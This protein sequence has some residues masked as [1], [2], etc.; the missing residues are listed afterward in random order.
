[1]LSIRASFITAFGIVF[2]SILAIPQAANAEPVTISSGFVSVT[3]NIRDTLSFNFSGD[4]LSANGFNLHAAVPQYMSP[5]LSS[6]SLC[7]PGDL[8]FPNSLIQLSAEP[9]SG[10]SVTFNGT[11]V[12]V[13]WAAQDSFLQ[14]TGS[15]VVIPSGADQITLT[16][17]F[18]MV[19]TIQVHPLDD[20]GS[21][22]FSTEINGSGIATLT[23]RRPGGNPAGFAI[24][25]ARYDFSPAAVPEP[26]TVILLTTGLAG[27]VVRKWRGGRRSKQP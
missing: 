8:I 18:D 27:I 15:G 2:L 5:C 20:P 26:A 1:M 6:P 16:M 10:S 17:P 25:T 4:G 3:S 22:I 19:G 21:V 23:L 12:L 9:G 14:F 13:S 24:D 11:T 7:Q